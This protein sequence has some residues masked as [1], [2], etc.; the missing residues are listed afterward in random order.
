MF[1]YDSDTR[2][3]SDPDIGCESEKDHVEGVT[4]CLHPS[5]HRDPLNLF[6]EKSIPGPFLPGVFL[7]RSPPL[8]FFREIKVSP[9]FKNLPPGQALSFLQSVSPPSSSYSYPSLPQLGREL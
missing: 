1:V 4:V 9:R 8:F 3:E 6:S 7:I 2:D 5:L